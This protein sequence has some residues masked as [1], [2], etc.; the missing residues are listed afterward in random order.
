[1]QRQFTCEQCGK[2]FADRFRPDR[3]RRF[4]SVEC[5]TDASK[6]PGR[7]RFWQKIA[8]GDVDSCWE[9]QR[10]RNPLG[11]GRFR[12]EG[13]TELA[14]RIAWELTHGEI[15][16]GM[17]VCHSCDNPPCCNPAH[18]WLG[19]NAE[20]IKDAARKGRG[21]RGGT[22][23]Y[24]S[25]ADH[26]SAKLT[27]GDVR[28]IRQR[29]SEGCPSLAREFGITRDHVRRIILRQAWNRLE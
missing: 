14:H 23:P 26:P 8:V 13:K 12:F 2:T 20:N 21:Y 4:C 16:V 9:W 24:Y 7:D 28:A 18:L 6:V 27:E 5:R 17:F 1:M 29:A 11:Y 22:P 10:F 3:V 15:P 25:G 19:T